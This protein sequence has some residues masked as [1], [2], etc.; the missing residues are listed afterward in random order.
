MSNLNQQQL[1]QETFLEVPK[2]ELR[3]HSDQHLANELPQNV[4]PTEKYIH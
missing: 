4:G 3:V 1:E 2:M